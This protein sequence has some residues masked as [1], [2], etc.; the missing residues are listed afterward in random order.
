MVTILR[1]NTTGGWIR[2]RFEEDDA[3]F[4]GKGLNNERGEIGES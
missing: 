4:K 3:S 1:W 2:R